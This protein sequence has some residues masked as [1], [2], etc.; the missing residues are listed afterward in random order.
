MGIDRL[1]GLRAMQDL[2][3]VFLGMSLISS[4]SMV[5]VLFL[6]FIDMFSS[7][8]SAARERA[9]FVLFLIGMGS[10]LGVLFCLMLGLSGG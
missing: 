7:I 6:G 2:A 9:F 10:L 5:L 1:R 3:L 4:V 8:R